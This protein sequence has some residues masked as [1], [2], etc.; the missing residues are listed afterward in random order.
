[1]KRPSSNAAAGVHEKVANICKDMPSGKVLDAPAGQGALSMRL[2]EIGHKISAFD[3]DETS[4]RAENKGIEFTKG[5]LNL[6]LPY[7]DSSFDCVVCVEGLEHLENIYHILRQFARILR[8]GGK[9]IITTPNIVSLASRIKFMLFGSFRYYNSKV[10]IADRSLASHISPLGFSQLEYALERSG[11]TIE[12]VMTNTDMNLW[13]VPRSVVAALYRWVN[14]RFNKAYNPVLCSPDILFGEI[15]I[16][17][18]R[19]SQ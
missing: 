2:V 6:D 1:M 14:L 7:Q 8:P 17:E 13:R 16:I 9:L 19:R 4:F 3:I 18:A 12:K 5:N 11:F 10:D 15:V